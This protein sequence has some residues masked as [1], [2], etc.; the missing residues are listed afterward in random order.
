MTKTAKN[1]NTA[2]K[3]RNHR[4]ITL[5]ASNSDSLMTSDHLNLIRGKIDQATF[6]RKLV[7]E[8]QK[9]QK[10]LESKEAASRWRTT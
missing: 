9:F 1:R 6:D 2:K 8:K 7:A 10:N 4:N 3:I 5:I